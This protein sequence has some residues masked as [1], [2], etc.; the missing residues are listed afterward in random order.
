MILDLQESSRVLA[1]PAQAFGMKI[2]L[3]GASGAIASYVLRELLACNHELVGVGRHPPAI[4]D[5]EFRQASIMDAQ[6]LERAFH[7]VD[8][9][10]HLAAITSPYRASAT[11]VIDVNVTGTVRVLEG[12]VKAGASHVVVASSGAATGFSFPASDRSPAYLPLDEEHPCEPDDSYGLSKLLGELA[13][14]RWTRAHGI[15]TIC[16]RINSC[17]YVDRP[18]AALAV[19]GGWANG[20]TVEDLWARYRLQLEEPL[21]PRSATAPPLPRDL[22]WA[23]TD[24]RDA[25]QAF[26]LAIENETIGHEVFLI[27]GFDTCSLVES[28]V[29]VAEHLPGVPLR[30]RLPGYSTLWSYEKA[31]TRLGYDPQHSWRKSDFAGWLG[32]QKDMQPPMQREARLSAQSGTSKRPR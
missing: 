13:C 8:A 2:A 21:R 15:R 16:L 7:G 4:A 17:W 14:A 11:N 5:I 3:T 26:R 31:T 24:A 9:I 18:G 28:E 30:R 10:V 22:L 27:N 1:G 20:L 32:D 25:A 23:V 19:R 12:A 29:L 6:S